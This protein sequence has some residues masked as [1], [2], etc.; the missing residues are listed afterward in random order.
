MKRQW[1]FAGG[2]LLLL[3]LAIG[4]VLVLDPLDRLGASAPPVEEL[5]VERAILDEN[6]ISVRVRADGSEPVT[7]AQ[8]QVD[9]AF[10]SFVQRPAGPLG[11]LE[12]AWIDIPYPWVKGEAHHVKLLTRTGATFDYAIEV[13]EPTPRFTTERTV[14][15]GLLG[16]FIGVLPVALGVLVYPFL[17]TLGRPGLLFV[18]ALTVGLL[19]FLFVDTISEGLEVAEHAAPTFQAGA[20]VWLA[21]LLAF[22]FLFAIGRRGRRPPDGVALAWYMALGIGLHNLGEGLAVGSAFAAGQAA[23]GAFLVVGFTLHNLTEG[24]GIASPVVGRGATPLTWVGLVALAGLPAVIGSWI[25]AFAYSPQW[26]ALFLAIGA[27]AILQVIVEVSRYLIQMA[28]DSQIRGVTMN[29]VGGF[30]CGLM[31][32]YGTRLLVPL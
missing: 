15:Y 24:I 1:I 12:P 16:L 26:T 32:M 27:G 20:L 9:D 29:T 6:G 10:W 8:V 18:L 13:A 22:L 5:T 21:G 31:V 23:L 19:A 11:R 25:G 17:K 4:A 28:P 14:A 2:P 30:A 7:I 3:A